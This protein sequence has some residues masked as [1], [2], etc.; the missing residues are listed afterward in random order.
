MELAP[1]Y[2]GL[3]RVTTATAIR[4]PEGPPVSVAR[5]FRGNGTVREPG[6]SKA[7]ST[8]ILVRVALLPPAFGADGSV[9]SRRAG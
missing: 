8:G 3:T 6:G 5:M 7:I 1:D 9:W 2:L 4:L